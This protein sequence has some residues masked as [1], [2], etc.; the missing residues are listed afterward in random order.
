MKKR[1]T[2]DFGREE[3]RGAQGGIGSERRS[4]GRYPAPRSGGRGAVFS[5]PVMLGF[6]AVVLLFYLCNMEARA[7]ELKDESEIPETYELLYVNADTFLYEDA[8]EASAV[9][10]ELKKQELVV[11][12]ETGGAWAKVTTGG[13][14]GY[15]KSE[16][17]QAENPDPQAVQEIAEQERWDAEFIDEVERLLKEKKRSRIYGIIVVCL[18]VGI[19]AAG[20]VSTVVR[21][22]Q[23]ER[24]GESEKKLS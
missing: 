9:L 1:N 12:V 8:D 4:A 16:Y 22:K 5:L 13:V 17:V 18:I 20:I 19:F 6:A 10:R 7:L 21:R 2:M 14:T 23:E 3:R 11:P 24:V 15:V